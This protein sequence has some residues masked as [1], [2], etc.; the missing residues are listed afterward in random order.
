M[1]RMYGLIV[2]FSIV[3]LLA[4]TAQAYNYNITPTT[5]VKNVK[6][7]TSNTL[8]INATY[9]FA[10]N[11]TDAVFTTLSQN[12]PYFI[13]YISPTSYWISA[14]ST[15]N[16]S[17]ISEWEIDIPDYYP[18][19]IYSGNFYVSLANSTNS[20]FITIPVNIT[21]A[22]ISYY[23]IASAENQTFN[24]NSSSEGRIPI[25][26]E[27]KGNTDV[28]INVTL[29]G[30]DV[31]IFSFTK[32]NFT[33][34]RGLTDVKY[35]DYSIP[36]NFSGIKNI[37]L[38]FSNNQSIYLTFNVTDRISPVI[39]EI[40]YPEHSNATDEFK[41][42]INASDNVG[43][44]NLTIKDCDGIE[45]SLQLT[46]V[47]YQKTYIRN[48]LGNCIYHIK[49]SDA[50]GNY[51][52]KNITVTIDASETISYRNSILIPKAKTNTIKRELML[53]VN[54]PTEIT[55]TLSSF[56]FIESNSSNATNS[57]WVNYN[58]ATSS[59]F[60]LLSLDTE[61]I[62]KIFDEIGDNMSFITNNQIYIK[63][64]SLKQG[65]YEG[66]F[67]IILPNY[68]ANQ[69]I[70]VDF[71]GTINDYTVSSPFSS[72][73]GDYKIDCS[74]N[75]TGIY[76]TSKYICDIFYPVDMDTSELNCIYTTK[77]VNKI[78]QD[79]RTNLDLKQS[80]IESMQAWSNLIYIVIFI[81][82]IFVVFYVFIYPS[83]R[84]R[85]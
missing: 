71:S 37:S 85:F 53:T 35:L 78:E 21:V 33:L 51:A 77:A 40:D 68:I 70:T 36:S 24:L 66:E 18:S 49:A 50:S 28:N 32:K 25:T 61:G 58:M 63:V 3:L 57:S 73:I 65:S 72:I 39:T 30:D 34:Y 14:N 29:F 56:R 47:I 52:R 84:L 13:V 83:L 74:A 1:L 79:C 67:K 26:I 44:A 80:E 69:S 16:Q 43:I 12:L 9:S 82:I 75:D 15:I 45:D 48:T 41:I 4:V 7:G 81:V 60:F 11:E 59:Q 54:K 76:D 17:R 5:I 46:N 2:I 19:G 62:E 8:D 42:I 22:A 20:S 38:T 6:P 31:G 23:N 27:N 10:T 55:Y 64:R